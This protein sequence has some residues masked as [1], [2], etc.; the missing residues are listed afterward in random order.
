MGTFSKRH[1]SIAFKHIAVKNLFANCQYSREIGNVGSSVC[2][3]SACGHSVAYWEI[4]LSNL[5]ENSRAS[6]ENVDLCCMQTLKREMH[7]A[8]NVSPCTA[9]NNCEARICFTGTRYVIIVPGQ[10]WLPMCINRNKKKRNVSEHKM[11]PSPWATVHIYS[12]VYDFGR[13]VFFLPTYTWGTALDAASLLIRSPSPHSNK[14]RSV[15]TIWIFIERGSGERLL[16]RSDPQWHTYGPGPILKLLLFFLRATCTCVYVCLRLLWAHVFLIYFICVVIF[17]LDLTFFLFCFDLIYSPRLITVITSN[18]ICSSSAAAPLLFCS[19]LFL[20]NPFSF[21]YCL[22]K[23]L[24]HI[25][26]DM[27]YI[28]K[29]LLTLLFM[30]PQSAPYR[31][32]RCSWVWWDGIKGSLWLFL[33]MA[34]KKWILEIANPLSLWNLR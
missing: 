5:V 29:G 18:V 24:C 28:N 11:I 22:V 9:P 17:L 20:F 31:R 21:L 15:G 34:P 30:A 13:K 19:P 32:R 16:L 6:S 1:R 2:V 23:P 10:R 12:F 14:R 27:C 7:N 3:L 4:S 33:K 25:S 8:A 26:S